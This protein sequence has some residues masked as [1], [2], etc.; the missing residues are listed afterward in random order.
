MSPKDSAY[1]E[2]RTIARAIQVKEYF[3]Q[4]GTTH[5]LKPNQFLFGNNPGEVTQ[6]E[7]RNNAT[8]KVEYFK[9][10]IDEIWREEEFASQLTAMYIKL[11]RT[12]V[13]LNPNLYEYYQEQCTIPVQV[14]YDRFN[15]I[16]E[17]VESK[18]K[19]GRPV[20][21]MEI[22]S[23]NKPRTSTLVIKEE[24]DIVCKIISPIFKDPL[25]WPSENRSPKS[26]FELVAGEGYE[27][28]THLLTDNKNK[29]HELL[30]K[31]AAFTTNRLKLL[32]KASNNQS[33]RKKD[34]KVEDFRI[35]LL[36][37][38]TK[39]DDFS[40]F[41]RTLTVKGSDLFQDHAIKEGICDGYSQPS[42]IIAAFDNHL[43]AAYEKAF[44]DDEKKMSLE[45]QNEDI[46]AKV[47][48]EKFKEAME[49][50]SKPVD[51]F[52]GNDMSQD[53]DFIE[54]QDKNEA[55]NLKDYQE[56]IKDSRER[57]AEEDI[58]KD[59]AE[60]KERLHAVD[61]IVMNLRKSGNAPGPRVIE[62]FKYNVDKLVHMS[63]PITTATLQRYANLC[64]EK[65]ISIAKEEDLALKAQ[66]LLDI[67]SALM[68]NTSVS[69]V[70]TPKKKQPNR[71]GYG[72]QSV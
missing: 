69:R 4:M 64:K 2:A 45:D 10:K 53:E 71:G 58:L 14:L 60:Y 18:D 20:K 27:A 50:Y 68:A 42:E 48:E 34:V 9:H 56:F 6:V 54:D 22:R 35:W 29:R 46:L 52:D 43:D 33:L 32:R 17:F 30:Q 24:H 39:V 36:E 67:K 26:L 5:L 31:F 59:L 21:K 49:N 66:E 28:I 16:T 57:E 65:R 55:D 40:S 51:R 38:T 63:V 44:R 19:R 8:V 41:A 13:L 1:E 12:K 72:S 70:K 11:I 15:K 23:L 62:S 47:H 37:S 7:G 3:D 61:K 25:P